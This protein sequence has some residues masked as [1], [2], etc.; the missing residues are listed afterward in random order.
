MKYQPHCMRCDDW[1]AGVTL[2]QG[3]VIAREPVCKACGALAPEAST[4]GAGANEYLDT[5]TD[6]DGGG[7]NTCSSRQPT[8]NKFTNVPLTRGW[9]REQEKVQT[10][11]AA[12]PTP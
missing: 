5:E 4:P 9:W 7:D 12:C 11:M 8:F 6:G 3:R 10:F 2:G 1:G